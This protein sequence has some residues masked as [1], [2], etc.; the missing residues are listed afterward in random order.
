M[1]QPLNLSAEK[2]SEMATGRFFPSFERL[3]GKCFEDCT[4]RV[5]CKQFTLLVQSSKQLPRNLSFDGENCP[6]GWVDLLPSS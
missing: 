5:K 6:V 3:R 4:E 2:V 1:Y